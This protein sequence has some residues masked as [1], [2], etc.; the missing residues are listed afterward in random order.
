MSPRTH[1]VVM[2][3]NKA[4]SVSGR[5][6]TVHYRGQCLLV[7]AIDCRSPMQSVWKPEKKSNPRAFFTASVANVCIDE[8]TG[9]AVLT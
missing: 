2:H 1:K 5:P 7:S 8:A 9:L 6:W 4:G 3:F